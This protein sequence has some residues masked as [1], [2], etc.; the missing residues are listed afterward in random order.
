MNDKCLVIFQIGLIVRYKS[1]AMQI[2]DKNQI[3]NGKKT[4]KKDKIYF[5]VCSMQKN[6]KAIY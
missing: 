4:N 6:P 1:I 3:R 2:N 5:F